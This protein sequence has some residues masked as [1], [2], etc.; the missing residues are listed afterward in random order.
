MITFQWNGYSFNIIKYGKGTFVRDMAGH[1]HAANSYELHYIT[2]GSGLL[3]TDTGSYPLSIGDFFI[4]G[5][6]TYH[7]QQTDSSSPLSEVCIYLQGCGHKTN[8]YLV[9]S[10]LSRNFY[11]GKQEALSPLFEKIIEEQMQQKIGY[12]SIISGIVQILLT[13]VTRLYLPDF[14]LQSKHVDSLDDRRFLLIE[15]AFINNPNITLTALADTIGLCERQ[16]QRLLKKY[17]GQTFLQK[18]SEANSHTI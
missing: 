18:K 3:K 1:S 7:Q 9:S 14:A 15:E 8:H 17:Y 2:G 5:P 13:E 12:E 11:F 10:F 4:T 6:N 16:T